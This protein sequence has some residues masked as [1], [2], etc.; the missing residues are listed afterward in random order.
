MTL[1]VVLYRETEAVLSCSCL[2]VVGY[3]HETIPLYGLWLEDRS[4]YQTDFWI[5]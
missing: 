3:H 2:T 1:K 4:L 5:L